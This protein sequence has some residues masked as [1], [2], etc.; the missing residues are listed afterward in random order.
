MSSERYCRVCSAPLTV[1]ASAP[2]EAGICPRCAAQGGA[3]AHP[4]KTSG[5]AVWSLV[6]AIVSWVVCALPLLS[7]PAII[8]GMLGRRAIRK[9]GGRLGGEGLAMGGIVVGAVSL[10]AFV[11]AVVPVV[12]WIQRGLNVAEGVGTGLRSIQQGQTETNFADIHRACRQYA[13]THENSY[14]P[15]LEALVAASLCDGHVIQSPISHAVYGYA[16]AGLTTHDDPRRVVAWTPDEDGGPQRTVLRLGGTH[17]VL[18]EA[19]WRSLA[20][21]AQED[22]P[23][24]PE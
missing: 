19:R 22:T 24:D 23:V 11:V 17:E 8:L 1:A 7:V 13:A 6:L 18:G 15:D 9:S 4:P 10:L 20:L 2:G 12:M 3:V 14:P 16:G 21:P 5:M